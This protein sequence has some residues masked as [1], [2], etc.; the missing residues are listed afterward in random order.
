MKKAL[1]SLA[2]AESE[3]ECE[4]FNNSMNRAYYA[5]F[6]AAISA[7]LRHGIWR[8]DGK[9]PHTFVQSEFVGKLINRRRHYPPRMRDTLS[10]LQD[11]RH[12]ADYQGGTISRAEANLA[13]RRCKEFV[14]TVR[15]ESE[16]R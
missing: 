4:R 7:M 5:T 9:W 2:G 15:L 16:R 13:L 3:L 1:E 12:H 8:R 11:L 14:E 6:Q 10:D